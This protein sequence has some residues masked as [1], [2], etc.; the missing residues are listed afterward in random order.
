MYHIHF[1]PAQDDLVGG[2]LIFSEKAITAETV[3][4]FKIFGF[5]DNLDD[6]DGSQNGIAARIWKRRLNYKFVL[7]PSRQILVMAGYVNPSKLN[8]KSKVGLYRYTYRLL[9]K[10]G[11]YAK[12]NK[13][14][15]LVAADFNLTSIFKDTADFVLKIE[16]SECRMEFCG[17]K[18]ANEDL[19]FVENCGLEMITCIRN[20]YGNLLDLIYILRGIVGRFFVLASMINLPFNQIQGKFH[21][22]NC[23]PD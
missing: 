4:F 1:D 10:L 23:T 14:E 11:T 18:K 15:L 6:I 5:R 22:N 16:D 17:L 7:V 12:T 13:L 21:K 2:I 8:I 20:S 9:E 3:D 19:E